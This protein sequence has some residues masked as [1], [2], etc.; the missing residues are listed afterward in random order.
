MVES[1]S[2]DPAIEINQIILNRLESKHTVVEVSEQIEF[3]R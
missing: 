3:Y 1:S 2:F